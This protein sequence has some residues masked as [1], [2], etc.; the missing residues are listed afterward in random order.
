MLIFILFSLLSVIQFF[1]K[2]NFSFEYSTFH[3]NRSVILNM[4]D[5]HEVARIVDSARVQTLLTYAGQLR[6]TVIVRFAFGI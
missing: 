1:L 6:E 5:F 2:L 3:A 4:T